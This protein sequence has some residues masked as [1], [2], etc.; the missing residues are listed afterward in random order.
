MK[1][2]ERVQLSENERIARIASGLETEARHFVI[3]GESADKVLLRENKN[4]FN[5]KVDE[6]SDKINK[7]E[8]MVSACQDEIQ[9]DMND[10]Q[11]KP[12]LNNLLIK[13]YSTNPFQKIQKTDSGLITD[14]GGFAPEYKSNETGE[15]EEEK[16]FVHT[17]VI[18]EVGGE[19]KYAKVGDT[20]FWTAP[21]EVPLPFFRQGLVL[22]NENR[23]MALVNTDLESREC[24]M[25]KN[26]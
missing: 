13:P 10:L 16:Q 11:I 17:G 20:A 14:L 15:I 25:S 8:S 24:Y 5:K 12:I 19:C 1:E 4:K 26:N 21:S 2:I 23:I 6:M 3:N 7:Y 18:V 22:V 9:K